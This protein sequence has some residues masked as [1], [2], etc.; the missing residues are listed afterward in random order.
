[1]AISEIEYEKEIIAYHEKQ[2]ALLQEEDGIMLHLKRRFMDKKSFD[3]YPLAV[4]VFDSLNPNLKAL[5]EPVSKEIAEI[6][7]EV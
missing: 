7:D 4:E 3:D 1:M 6:T 2:Q 5:R